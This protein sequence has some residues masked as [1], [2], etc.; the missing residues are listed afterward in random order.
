MLIG[1]SVTA[2]VSNTV[3]SAIM[4]GRLPV[5]PSAL[6]RLIGRFDSSPL[7][8][9]KQRKL[10]MDKKKIQLGMNPSTASQRLLKDL[11]FDFVIKSGYVCHK[12]GGGL[13][14]DTFSIEHI[15]PWLD[16]NN[17]VE[18]F[19]NLENIGYS[20]LVCNVGSRRRDKAPHGTHRRYT[21]GCRCG[22]CKNGHAEH[23]RKY[24]TKESRRKRYLEGLPS[25]P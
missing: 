14:R 3:S 1:E 7:S 23:A 18:L 15:V 8:Q 21:N 5:G 17:P 24:Y 4:R 16:S 12:C 25:Q 10:V 22:D 20:H 11:L 19:F 9:I 2:S 6:N 13:T